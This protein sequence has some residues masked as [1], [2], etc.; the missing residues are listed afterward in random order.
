MI[1]NPLIYRPQHKY[2]N[3]LFWISHFTVAT[4]M[5]VHYVFPLL[6]CNWWKTRVFLPLLE[7]SASCTIE[8]TQRWREATGFRTRGE[9]RYN[10]AVVPWWRTDCYPGE[11]LC[12]RIQT[13]RSPPL[14]PPAARTRAAVVFSPGTCW[15]RYPDGYAAGIRRTAAS[16]L[17][18]KP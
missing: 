18:V 12:G 10:R 13:P 14:L 7:V 15:T 8:R 4:F 3:A 16:G 5:P 1:R 9:A 6:I 11:P 17:E 2:N